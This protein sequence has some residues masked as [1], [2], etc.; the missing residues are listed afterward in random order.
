MFRS[1]HVFAALPLVAVTLS[2]GAGE[3]VEEHSNPSLDPARGVIE[4]ASADGMACNEGQK[5]YVREHVIKPKC[6][7]EPGWACVTCWGEG[8]ITVHE[9]QCGPPPPGC[10]AS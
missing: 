3:P 1:L 8:S 6:G 7:G 5:D 9:V 10:P 2:V 4:C